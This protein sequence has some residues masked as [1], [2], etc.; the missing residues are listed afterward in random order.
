M[1]WKSWTFNEWLGLPLILG[2]IGSLFYLTLKKILPGEAFLGVM[3]PILTLAT[4]YYYRKRLNI[5]K[6]K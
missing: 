5:D 4:Q 1:N 3:A 6:I 2:I